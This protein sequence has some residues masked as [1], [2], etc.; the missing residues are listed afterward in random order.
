[1]QTGIGGQK[2]ARG[3]KRRAV[4]AVEGPRLVDVHVGQ[5]I[6]MRRLFKGMSQSDLARSL[7][8]TFQQV[9]KYE[10]GMNRVSASRLYDLSRVLEVPVSFFFDDLPEDAKD[11]A[12][13]PST[14]AVGLAEAGLS[15][16]LAKRET[17]ELVRAYYSISDLT[18]RKRVYDMIKALGEQADGGLDLDAPPQQRTN[19]ENNGAHS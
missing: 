13:I 1:M 16:P 10:R 6:R 8:L 12:R 2:M 3:T 4:V 18:L 7:G 5:R 14:D 9:Q 19:E 11:D 17:A 15:D